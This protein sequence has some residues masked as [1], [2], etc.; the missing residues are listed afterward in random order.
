M[1]ALGSQVSLG[2]GDGAVRGLGSCFLPLLPLLVGLGVLGLF[3]GRACLG[4]VLH[5]TTPEGEVKAWPLGLREEG[6]LD[7]RG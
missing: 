3:L 7:S 4:W 2:D 5:G 6:G 1:R